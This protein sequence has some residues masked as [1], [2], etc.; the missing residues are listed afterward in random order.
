MYMQ[1]CLFLIYIPFI[2]QC[3]TC[4]HIFLLLLC[5]YCYLLFL[6]GLKTLQWHLVPKQQQKERR[7][8]DM[9]SSSYTTLHITTQ[10]NVNVWGCFTYIYLHVSNSIHIRIFFPIFSP[11]YCCYIGLRAFCW[12]PLFL[13]ILS[14]FSRCRT[15]FFLLSSLFS[16]SVLYLKSMTVCNENKVYRCY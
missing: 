14:M 6:P 5:V 15:F 2:L 7:R 8:K 10:V 3:K 13:S 11:I 16:P 1:W 9:S 4:F 12:H